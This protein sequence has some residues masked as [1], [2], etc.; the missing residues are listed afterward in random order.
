MKHKIWYGCAAVGY[1]L[2]VT[3]MIYKA[4]ASPVPSPAPQSPIDTAIESMSQTGKLE[5]PDIGEIPS[6]KKKWQLFRDIGACESGN[7][8]VITAVQGYGHD[9]GTHQIN[10]FYHSVAAARMGY[11][12]MIPRDNVLYAI[13]LYETQGTKPWY[14]SRKCWEGKQA[15]RER[16]NMR[17]ASEK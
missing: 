14:I 8:F 17:V 10:T 1:V 16:Q 11:D 13:H 2:I 12:L 15:E 4:G 6:E 9:V 7:R 3:A 5:F